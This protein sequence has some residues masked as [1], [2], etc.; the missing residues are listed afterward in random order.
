M[1]RR[2]RSRG[3]GRS[4]AHGHLR[5][6]ISER[7]RPIF[8]APFARSTA[9]ARDWFY[10]PAT[11]RRWPCISKRSPLQSRPAHTPFAS[12]KREAIASQAIAE[13]WHVSKTLPV[14][15]NITL[16]SLPPKSPE[17][18]PVENIW[19]FMRDNWLSNR[20]FT[21]YANIVDHCCY[22]WNKLVDQPWLIM[23]IGTRQWANRSAHCQEF[24]AP[25]A[26][27]WGHID[28]MASQSLDGKGIC[29]VLS[30][31]KARFLEILVQLQRDKAAA[32]RLLRTLLRHQAF[33]P[34][35]IVTD[36]LRS[37]GAPLR[38][39][40]FSGLHEQGLRANDRAENSHQPLR[41]RERKMQVFKS[42]KLARPFIT[43]SM[44][45]GI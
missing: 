24:A 33:V 39:I 22:A 23:S 8:S 9:R 11:P 19:Q 30:T 26:C 17:L 21:S 37:Y 40:G 38:G 14:P 35:V 43:R 45:N 10:R 3:V 31:A 16:V 6:A 29:G 42:T 32:V 12:I 41:R 5:R 13:V 36:K 18:N 4:V 7:P 34:K 2:I 27:T 44:C 25:K 28:E 15:P 20:V 1:A